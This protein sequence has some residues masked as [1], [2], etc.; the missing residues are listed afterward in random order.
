MLAC[1]HVAIKLREKA[2]AVILFVKMLLF[3][4]RNHKQELN[5]QTTE[6]ERMQ[7]R[8]MLPNII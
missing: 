3:C 2:K 4:E 8:Q 7:M 1:Q 5:I 6:E